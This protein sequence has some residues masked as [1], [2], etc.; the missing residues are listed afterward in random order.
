MEPQLILKGP[1]ACVT[2]WLHVGSRSTATP[3]VPD[4]FKEAEHE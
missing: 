2:F 4:P 3:L 1:G